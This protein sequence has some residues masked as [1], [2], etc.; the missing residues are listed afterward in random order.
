MGSRS[1]RI[2]TVDL[3]FDEIFRSYF[4]EEPTG[5]DA[6]EITGSFAKLGVGFE[7]VAAPIVELAQH[8][9]GGLD[10]WGDL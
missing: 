4:E 8:D 7:V 1:K 9:N 3:C 2:A 10:S 6:E 5:F